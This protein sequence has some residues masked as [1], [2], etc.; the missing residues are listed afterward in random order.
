[1]ILPPVLLLIF[2]RPDT[3]A[4]VMEALR[5]A[6]PSRVYVAADGPREGMGEDERCER[7]RRIATEVNWPCEIKTLF[8]KCNL[9]CGRALS[10]AID[11]FFEH[12]EQGII[13]E[14]DCVPSQS[15]FPYCAE[16]L[17]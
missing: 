3:T 10:G 5:R 14:D 12:E 6:R 4:L 16:L 1:M 9:G 13:L 7:A 8:R 15:F 17:D 2:N 11:W